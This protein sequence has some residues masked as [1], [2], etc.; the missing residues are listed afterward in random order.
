MKYKEDWEIARGRWIKWW[1]NE[2]DIALLQVITPREKPLVEID[3]PV[4]N[5]I[6]GR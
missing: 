4:V 5:S 6:E 1:N 2:S 3:V